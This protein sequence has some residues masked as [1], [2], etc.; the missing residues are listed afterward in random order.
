MTHRMINVDISNVWCDLSLPDLLEIE[1]EVHDAHEMLREGTGA[2]AEFRDWMD[3]PV[4]ESTEQIE[5]ILK[6]AEKI[7]GD[8]DVCV[9]TGIGGSYLGSRAAE[10]RK[11]QGG[12]SDLLCR[13]YAEHPG[14]E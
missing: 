5:R 1:K 2:G 10:Y 4:R 11:R 13:K 7:R 6:A 8:S 9:V 12:S 14:M 3:L